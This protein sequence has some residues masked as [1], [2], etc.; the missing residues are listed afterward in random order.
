MFKTVTGKRVYNFTGSPIRLMRQDGKFVKIPVDGFAPARRSDD[1]RK[2]ILDDK[3]SFTYLDESRRYDWYNVDPI[4]EFIPQSE[5]DNWVAIVTCDYY[6]ACRE[7]D[8]PT[9][10]LYTVGTPIVNDDGITEGYQYL[11]KR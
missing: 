6:Y 1:W 10:R 8:L 4:E 5:D 3:A 2:M 11:I 7:M 9:D